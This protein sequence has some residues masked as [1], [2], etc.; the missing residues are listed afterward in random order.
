MR[1]LYGYA[2]YVSTT[3]P[4]L[5]IP[6][7]LK[8]SIFATKVVNRSAYNCTTWVLDTCAIDHIICFVNLFTS[9]TSSTK[10]VVEL[11]NGESAQVT[12][13]GLVRVS[14]NLVLENVLCVPSVSFNLLSISKL[15]QTLPYCLLF[16]LNLVLFRTFQLGR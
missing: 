8:N 3:T 10:C 15:T 5:A 9:I 13:V 1:L 6:F 11:P 2:R 16:S 12:H 4:L 14:S 7:N